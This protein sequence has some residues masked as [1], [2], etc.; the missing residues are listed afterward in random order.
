MPQQMDLPQIFALFETLGGALYGGEAVSQLEHAL[1]CAFAAEQQGESD[2][3]IVAALLHDIGHLVHPSEDQNASERHQEIGAA[4]IGGL[5]SEQVGAIIRL[6]V[7]AK[8]YRCAIDADCWATLS[9]A[10]KYS[11]EYQGGP[12]KPDEALHF[13]ALPYADAAIRVRLYD[14]AAK[15]VGLVTPDLG[16]Y[17]AICE[18]IVRQ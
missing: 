14:E 17:R 1:Q 16:H 13:K 6:H 12:F 8:R 4:A 15:I 2:E 11:L 5:F 10:S 3:I 18:R 7:A 9:P